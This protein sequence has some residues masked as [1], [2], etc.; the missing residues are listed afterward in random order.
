MVGFWMVYLLCSWFV[1]GIYCRVVGLW[2]VSAAV[3]LV[4]G[5]KLQLC[6]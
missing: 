1:N 2:M 4:C 5:W 3:W 6:S